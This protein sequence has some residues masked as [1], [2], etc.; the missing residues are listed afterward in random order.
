[1][2]ALLLLSF[3]VF[4]SSAE[5]FP[6]TDKP[7]VEIVKC[8]LRSEKIF[9]SV[10]GIIEVI[11][12]KNMDKIIPQCVMFGSRIVAEVQECLKEEP[13]LK[14]VPS[15]LTYVADKLERFGDDFILGLYKAYYDKGI[16]GAYNYCVEKTKKAPECELLKPLIDDDDD[17]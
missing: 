4:I 17:D 10:A 14:G 9:D 8:V 1:M 7:V 5:I 3:L 2:K 15:M 11:Q 6:K 16:R 12:T 13:T